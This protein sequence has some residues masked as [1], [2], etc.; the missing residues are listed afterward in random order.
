MQH[1]HDLPE[2]DSAWCSCCRK[3]IIKGQHNV[4]RIMLQPE[5]ILDFKGNLRGTKG[6]ERPKAF[7]HA[8]CFQNHHHHTPGRIE[9]KYCGILSMAKT[10]QDGSKI[11]DICKCSCH[12]GKDYCSLLLI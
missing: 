11:N 1:N 6:K 10:L 7:Y 4:V 8:Q 2:A 3:S 9:C 5:R 12:T